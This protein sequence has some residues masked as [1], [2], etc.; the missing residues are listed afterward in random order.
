MR[1]FKNYQSTFYLF[2]TFLLLFSDSMNAQNPSIEWKLDGIDTLVYQYEQEVYVP[3]MDQAMKE[4]SKTVSVS[5]GD[6]NLIVE[7]CGEFYFEISSIEEEVFSE[8]SLGVRT[9]K[10]RLDVP[11]RKYPMRNKYGEIIGETRDE[12]DVLFNLIFPIPDKKLGLW[13]TT[14]I[15]MT[16]PFSMPGT[17]VNISGFTRVYCVE[18]D[19]VM[20]TFRS[21][22]D[23]AAYE[24]PAPTGAI[25]FCYLIGDG[26][27]FFDPKN[28]YYSSGKLNI[29][30]AFGSY[31]SDEK[32][33]MIKSMEMISEMK[34]DLKRVVRN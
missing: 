10:R 23:L 13:D 27:Y 25:M 17:V 24:I 32:R 15:P 6:F 8:D 20:A 5:R 11:T 12:E 22:M 33:S 29:E 3:M 16:F 30:M 21:E 1:N 4:E 14:E 31:D 9:F 26:E 19:P 34:F 2:F 7:D 18:N 28:G